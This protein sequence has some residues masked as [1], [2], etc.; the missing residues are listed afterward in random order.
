MVN[1]C[2]EERKVNTVPLDWKDFKESFLDHF[3][4]FE[5]RKEKVLEFINLWQG[6][7]SVKQYPFKL[8]ELV[9]YAPNIGSNST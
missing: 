6:K 1:Q 7:M 3:L 2:K 8:T 5:L 4:S 9:K